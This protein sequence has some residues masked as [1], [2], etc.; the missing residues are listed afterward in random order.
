MVAT[1][2]RTILENLDRIP[3]QEQRVKVA[4]VAFDVSLYFFTVT[5]RADSTLK[6]S[7]RLMFPS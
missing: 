4:I 3:D 2:S 1:A 5:V 6:R 7:T